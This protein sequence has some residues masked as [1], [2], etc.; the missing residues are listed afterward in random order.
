MPKIS[1][2]R[3]VL[4]V[5][6]AMADHGLPRRSELNGEEICGWI[7]PNRMGS[8]GFSIRKLPDGN[9]LWHVVLSGKPHLKYREYRD[10]SG[11]ET[12]DLHASGSAMGA[13]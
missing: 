4:A 9:I 11:E 10:V 13:H 12:L 3:A 2:I 5:K 6:G 1:G 8:T 7:E